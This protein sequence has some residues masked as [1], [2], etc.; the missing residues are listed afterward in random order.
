MPKPSKHR[1]NRRSPEL[2]YDEF[3][4]RSYVHLVPQDEQQD[5]HVSTSS[6]KKHSKKSRHKR[7]RDSDGKKSSLPTP[8]LPTQPKTSL[9]A[10]DDISSDSDGGLL[11]V[12]VNKR[13]ARAS[14]VHVGPSHMNASH[15]QK[16]AESPATAIRSYLNE[17]SQSNSPRPAYSPTY[18][19]SRKSSKRHRVYSPELHRGSHVET[20]NSRVYLEH[21]KAYAGD[22]PRAFGGACNA[23]PP[24]AKTSKRYRSPSPYGFNR[25]E[26]KDRGKSPSRK[27]K[28]RS[29]TRS[30]QSRY[31]KKNYSETR[32]HSRS[33]YVD[34]S[35]RSPSPSRGSSRSREPKF[36]PGSLAYELSKH[37]KARE[38]KQLRSR[39]E[40]Q[41]LAD[42]QRQ[43]QLRDSKDF[44]QVKR[45][46][47][48][49][50]SQYAMKKQ[51]DRVQL[52]DDCIVIKVENL[53]PGSGQAERRVMR[54][55][56]PPVEERRFVGENHRAQPPRP[57][58]M[59]QRVP[60]PDECR[61]V[62]HPP[63][64]TPPKKM[65]PLPALSPVDSSSSHSSYSEREP[66]P[67]R[68]PRKRITDLP[69]PPM[70]D[71]P[72]GD[73][74]QEQDQNVEPEMRR[75]QHQ[76]KIKK[77]KICSQR[78]N[79]ER[80]MG[81]WGE[82][83][84]DWF[85]ILEIIGEGT[86]GQVYKAKDTVSDE[87]VA[88][89]KVRLE[90]EKEGFPITAVREIKILRQLQHPNIVNLK[91]IVTDKQ[92]ASDFKKDKGA[93]YLVFEYMDHDL[94]GLLES[95]FVNF[96]E[97][98]IASFM[99]QLLDGLYYCHKKNFLHRD[100]KC[101]NI[102]L[103]NRGHIKLADLGLA[104][105]Y[106]ADDRDR[107]YTNKVITLWYRP[108]ELLLGEER[109]GPAIDVWSL[110]CI[111]GELFTRKPIFQANQE[112]LQL[113]LI[114]KTC[115]IP[116][117]AVWPDVI[118]LPL[119]HTFKPK[120][121]YRRRLREEFSFLPKLALDLMDHML[122]LDPGRRCTAEQGLYCPWLRD[123][124][125]ARIPPPDLPRDQDCH[126]LWC[127]N[128]KKLM[129]EQ[130]RKEQ[131][132]GGVP[133]KSTT[134]Q[135]MKL[136]PVGRGLQGKD[137]K[138]PID[139]RASGE[140]HDS[141][142]R[143]SAGDGK[144]YV[145]G[146]GNSKDS[147]PGLAVKKAETPESGG[148][149]GSGD[150]FGREKSSH[151]KEQAISGKTTQAQLSQLIELLKS[152]QGGISIKQIAKS[153]NISVDQQTTQ[154]LDNLKQQ[155]MEAASVA[156]QAKER[157]EPVLSSTVFTSPVD[158]VPKHRHEDTGYS[159]DNQQ[160]SAYSH[161][162]ASESSVFSSS[163]SV[164]SSGFTNTLPQTSG[165]V[166]PGYD[167]H[168]GVKAALAQ[169]LA[170]Q[171]IPVTMGGSQV[172]PTLANN[173]T[174]SV[175]NVPGPVSV[176]SS[177]QTYGSQNYQ[178]FE[179]PISSI[180]NSSIP[181]PVSSIGNSSVTQT[182]S[183]ARIQSQYSFTSDDSRE[184]FTDTSI[185]NIPNTQP[186][187]YFDSTARGR[188]RGVPP[189]PPPG[190]PPGFPRQQGA[191]F[192]RGYTGGQ[193][194]RGRDSYSSNSGMAGWH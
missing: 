25:S 140:S 83:C 7:S 121:Q 60:Q 183:S 49:L 172:R 125:P 72:E 59:Q 39:D 169:L 9:V 186:M 181:P 16:R 119:F 42:K 182:V 28:R 45:E 146:N 100:I 122:E 141:S 136:A 130:M 102:L 144:S 113:E 173:N 54:S 35:S 135:S 192:G 167:K 164:A 46:P 153:L 19:S 71:D 149:G 8:S 120:R 176:V 180:G 158:T 179:P 1:K 87:F 89:K 73:Y 129:R 124:I 194:N 66:E 170:Q 97:D 40:R 99:K 142:R 85:K 162:G 165:A 67:E 96:K 63:P 132:M 184:S 193:D 56:P 145:Y 163:L 20:N 188:G 191:G 156:K 23:S 161:P 152:Q 84:V 26:R 22:L 48:P 78:R 44:Q 33:Q 143:T 94:M 108:P 159:V 41:I 76:P 62:Y 127:K 95:G 106:C 92:D 3:D 6:R 24:P 154:L 38:N 171:G 86:Y 77:P 27:H 155:L 18:T 75:E 14:P 109:Y 177:G 37:R 15:S 21:P 57:D 11:S 150:G 118:K 51:Q 55:E 117:P 70:L 82:R 151:G 80:S 123:I 178:N 116:C 12:S 65:L 104:R 133:S 79:N 137:T 10:Y 115:G 126:E 36:A 139:M 131:E 30:S 34:S 190:P 64:Q 98:H 4:A 88:L 101:S 103:N 50:S 175:S 47:S 147:I 61:Q 81:D 189:G 166:Q 29:P 53:K 68:N 91:E 187:P 58:M 43:R 17:R 134:P 111:L 174:D 90:N 148:G 2:H 31:S 112:F 107:L 93:F 185:T 128:R 105:F 160:S 13:P 138:T 5:D 52:G 69:M 157:G 114:S 110:G 74:D 32:R 168:A